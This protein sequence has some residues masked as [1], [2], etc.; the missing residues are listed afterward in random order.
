MITITDENLKFYRENGYHIFHE[1]LLPAAKFAG[2]KSFFE[3]LLADLPEGKRPEAMDVPHFRF[4]QLLEWLLADE[5]LDVVE[6]MLGPDLILWSS[7]FIC[8]PDGDGQAV[9]WHEDS[10]YWGGRLEPHEVMTIWLAI[11]DST[12][13]NGCMRV[14]ARSH[15]NGFS[16]YEPVDATTNVFATQVVEEQLDLSRA[17]DLEI[18]SGE[19]HVHHAK[20]I[21]GSNANHSDQRRCGYTM[22]YMPASVKFTPDGRHTHGIYLAR[23]RDLAGNTYLDSDKP[24]PEILQRRW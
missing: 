6:R 8:K 11:D 9:P 2:L 22:R 24:L 13:E 18:K 14:I 17:V 10:A 1:Q 16:D 5:V 21:H 19:C 12:V 7:H 23:G 4:P 20:I 15:D 3:Q